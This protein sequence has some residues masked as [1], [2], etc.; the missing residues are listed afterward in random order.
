MIDVTHHGDDR[1]TADEVVLV[2]GFFGDGILHFSTYVFGG[3]TK[4]LCHDIDGLCI[5]ALVD[6]YHDTDA[7][8]GADYFVD[9]DIHH[10]G[11]FANRYKLG[12]LQYLALCSLFGHLAIEA[13]L[14]G[15][16]LFAAILRTLLVLT[17]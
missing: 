4:F 7:H 17:F 11:K 2:V 13:L 14:Y 15:I 3:E 6:T 9:T 12:Q 16:S 10:R 8:A 5:E 1:C